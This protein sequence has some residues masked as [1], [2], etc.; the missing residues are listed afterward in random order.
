MR[1][2]SH[3]LWIPAL[4][5]LSAASC[6][7]GTKSTAQENT[8][9]VKLCDNHTTVKINEDM[10]RT[11]E[12]GQMV[13][14][15]LM[16]QWKRSNPDA[17]WEE[18]VKRSHPGIP[19]PHDNRALLEGG[20]KDDQVYGR[21]TERDHALEH[22]EP[23]DLRCARPRAELRRNGHERDGHGGYPSARRDR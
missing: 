20:Q 2:T 11:R 7:S 3:A 9:E 22:A 4:L 18:D 16:S 8:S 21:A 6:S 13:A 12:N 1:T 17:N 5:A 14:D 23:G 10:P 19:K 15:A